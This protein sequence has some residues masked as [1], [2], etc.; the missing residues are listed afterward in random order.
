[1]NV[2]YF[3]FGWVRFGR[4]SGFIVFLLFTG[5]GG[6]LHNPDEKKET[7]SYPLFGVFYFRRVLYIGVT[8]YV[9]WMDIDRLTAP[10]GSGTI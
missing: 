1:M 5:S 6:T 9:I 10:I 4:F 8:M 3:S 2:S 7:S